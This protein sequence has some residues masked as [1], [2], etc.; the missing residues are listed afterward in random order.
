MEN[1]ITI[2]ELRDIVSELADNFMENKRYDVTI[3]LSH[4]TSSDELIVSVIDR[5]SFQKAVSIESYQIIERPKDA[6]DISR[7][8]KMAIKQHEADDAINIKDDLVP[9]TSC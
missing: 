8:I 6:I 5:G 1:F 2:D 9:N 4:C 7:I 3:S